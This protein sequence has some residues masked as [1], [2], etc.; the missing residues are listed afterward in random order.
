[1]SQHRHSEP[2][3]SPPFKRKLRF[4]VFQF[5]GLPF[6]LLIPLLAISGLFDQTR[7]ESEQSNDEISIHMDYPSRYRHKTE[8][9]ILI[10]VQN[11]SQESIPSLRLEISR[12]YLDQFSELRFFPELNQIS[13]DSYIIELSEIPHDTSEL[14]RIELLAS[15]YGEATG[16]VAAIAEGVEPLRLSINSFTYP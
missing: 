15:N 8:G 3:E 5:I 13:A 7:T 16:L 6:I 2:P 4:Y 10:H 1:M 12:D 9:T 14:I 11:N